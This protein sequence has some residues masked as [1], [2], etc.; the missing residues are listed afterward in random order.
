[1]EISQEMKI[2]VDLMC[3]KKLTE[4]NMTAKYTKYTSNWLACIPL[5]LH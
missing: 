4:T 2:C 5:T 1:M 3:I